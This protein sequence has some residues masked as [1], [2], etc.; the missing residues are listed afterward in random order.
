MCP[1]EGV[2]SAY[3]DGELLSPWK[4]TVEEHVAGCRICAAALERLRVLGQRL[5]AEREPDFVD[6]MARTRN[7]LAS[8]PPAG[9]GRRRPVSIPLPLAALAASLVLLLGGALVL[10]IIRP[11]ETSSVRITDSPTGMRQFEIR[12]DPEDIRK[13]LEVLNRDA[14]DRSVTI[15]IPKGFVFAS[16]GEP[17]LRPALQR[18]PR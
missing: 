13:I 15:E 18:V 10:T 14:V 16:F 1:E 11:W 2:L 8:G 17:E 12:G 9:T 6:A 3:L 4:D 5:H 7:A